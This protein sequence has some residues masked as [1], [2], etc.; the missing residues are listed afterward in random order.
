L[1]NKILLV[2]QKQ[3]FLIILPMGVGW[4]IFVKVKGGRCRQVRGGTEILKSMV[5]SSGD[6]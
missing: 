5:R 3:G 2:I 4:E 1:S 6:G